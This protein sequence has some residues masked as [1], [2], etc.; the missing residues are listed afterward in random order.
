MLSDEVGNIHK[1]YTIM[2]GLLS[3]NS[4]QNINVPVGVVTSEKLRWTSCLKT[5]EFI[6]Q[7]SGDWEV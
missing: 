4:F 5:T 1:L 7:S 6:S 3:H 2:V